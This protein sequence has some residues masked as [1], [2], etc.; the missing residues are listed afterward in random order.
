MIQYSIQTEEQV[1]VLEQVASKHSL[2]IFSMYRI[3]KIE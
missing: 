3:F 1:D 2:I